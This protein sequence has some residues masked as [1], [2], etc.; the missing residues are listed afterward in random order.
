MINR[1]PAIYEDEM[2]YSWFCRYLVNNGIW[3]KNEIAKELFVNE[4]DVIS[5]IFIGN[6]NKDVRNNIEQ[7]ISINDLLKYHTM[8]YVYTGYCSDDYSNK[9]LSNLKKNSYKAELSIK[10]PHNENRQLK[11]CPLCVIEDR[12]KYGEAYWHNIHQIRG[13]PICPVHNCKLH[14]SEI[15]YIGYG[16]VV[17]KLSPLEVININNCIEYNTNE[18]LDKIVNYI[19][20]RYY[21]QDIKNI[22][23]DYLSIKKENWGFR[24]NI[25]NFY[26]KYGI[27]FCGR[28]IDSMVH[29]NRKNFCTMSAIYYYLKICH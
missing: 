2:V 27:S 3:R 26:K 16:S 23:I 22:N 1:L 25:I 13:M 10:R 21:K 14:D 12:K 8:F 20:K 9:F 6:I 4:T 15:R 7:I 28:E 17:E 5:K 18:M 29:D 19:A 11:Y 24:S